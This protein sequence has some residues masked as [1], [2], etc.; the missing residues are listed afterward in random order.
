MNKILPVIGRSLV[1]AGFIAVLLVG[2]GQ[3]DQASDGS[4]AVV[5]LRSKSRDGK[6]DLGVNGARITAFTAAFSR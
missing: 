2:C 5:D 6:S 4:G 3:S 1:T